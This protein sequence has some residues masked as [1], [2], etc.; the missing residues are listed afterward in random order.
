M[1]SR[2]YLPPSLH[3]DAR[4]LVVSTWMDHLPFGYDLV[5]AMKPELLVE[6]G[7]YSG[8]SYFTFCQAMREQN[9]DGLAYAID[10]WD[11]DAHTGE[12]D[13]S[14][15][16]LVDDHARDYYRGISYLLRMRFD[17]AAPQFDEGSIDLLH[18]DG[19]HT[20]DAVKHDFETWFPRVRP[21][22]IVLFH[23][24]EARMPEFGVRQFWAELSAQHQSFA[25]KHGYGLGVLR[26]PGGNR[27]YSELEQL[28]FD[29]DEEGRR[30]L[31]DF[32]SHVGRYQD[33]LRRVRA[34]QKRAAAKAGS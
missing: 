16:R 19:L 3:F 30:R 13:D 4:H 24:I 6:L 29:G 10:T 18:I 31:Q 11:G 22:G 2:I 20:F 26:K 25:F 27:E 17:E 14:I 32:Y 15:F 9:V 28:M 1:T 23:D 5:A 7:T 12:Y 8:L 33:A 34:Q 21:G